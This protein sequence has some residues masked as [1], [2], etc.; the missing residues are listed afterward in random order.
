MAFNLGLKRPL[1]VQQFRTF[2]F[3]VGVAALPIEPTV[4]KTSLIT[5]VVISNPIAGISVF[6][7]NQGVTPTTGLEILPGTAP[8]FEIFQEGRQL[9]EIQGPLLDIDAGLQ[10]RNIQPEAIPFVVWSP[11]NMY[12]VSTAPTTVSIALFKAMYL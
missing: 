9:Y 8:S 3:N 2:A 7:G 12:L 4:D 5:T 6:W 10:C 1:I 11:A